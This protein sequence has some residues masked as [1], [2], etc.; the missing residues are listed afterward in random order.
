MR[1]DYLLCWLTRASV[2]SLKMTLAPCFV[3]LPGVNELCGG[4]PLRPAGNMGSC[5]RRSSL[6]PILSPL[7]S[8]AAPPVP[9]L[10]V[11]SPRD[12]IMQW[13]SITSYRA[14]SSLITDVTAASKYLAIKTAAQ[15]SFV[16]DAV[17][18]K[19]SA[20]LQ[21]FSQLLGLTSGNCLGHQKGQK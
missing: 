2:W 11:T 19:V 14:L 17:R 16:E 13:Q 4:T 9:L 5:Q 6:P 12:Q 18:K 21:W 7:R 15:S 20:V 1:Q 8:S 3:R 10:H